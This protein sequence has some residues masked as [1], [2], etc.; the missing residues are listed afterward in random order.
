MSKGTYIKL[1]QSTRPRGT[2]RA[3]TVRVT[4]IC[5]FNPRVRAGRDMRAVASV[6]MI[7]QFQSTRPRG[8]RQGIAG[9]AERLSAFQSTRPRGTRQLESSGI[10]L[11]MRFQSTRPRGTRLPLRLLPPL[12]RLF[13]STRPRGTRL[14]RQRSARRHGSFNPRVRAGRD[15]GASRA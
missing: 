9:I 12:R 6:L 2:R 8:T 11:P 15:D 13:Q 1:F 10:S 5:C 14:R 4:A 7:V 3:E